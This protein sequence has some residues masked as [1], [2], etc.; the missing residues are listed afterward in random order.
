MCFIL[1]LLISGVSP[2]VRGN[3]G[4]A[5]QKKLWNETFDILQ[6]VAP[7]IEQVF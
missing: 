3:E 1:H 6:K 4:K 5:T 7:E 2:F